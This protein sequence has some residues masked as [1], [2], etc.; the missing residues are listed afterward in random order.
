MFVSLQRRRTWL[1]T[2]RKNDE[3]HGITLLNLPLILPGFSL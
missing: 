2:D 3:I 1:I